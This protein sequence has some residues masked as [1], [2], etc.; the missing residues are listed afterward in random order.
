MKTPGPTTSAPAAFGSVLDRNIKALLDV[1]AESDRQRGWQER[2]SDAI[3]T[4]TGSP[5]FIYC[6]LA[7]LATWVLWN[8]GFLGIE[9]FDPFPFIL[10]AS[11][12]SVEAIFLSTFVL[13]NQNRMNVLA[14]RRGELA[15]QISLLTE[16]ELTR[17]TQICDS[18]AKRLEIQPQKIAEDIEEV[19]ADVSPTMV[20]EKIAQAEREH[21]S[22]E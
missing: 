6:H 8:L 5:A 10:L 11:A 15:L 2:V 14:Q 18:I 9:P 13:I 19:K 21:V 17:L 7:I 4:F 22:N 16:H 20:L 3:A 12:A 1:K